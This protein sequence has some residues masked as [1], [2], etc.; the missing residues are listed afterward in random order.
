VDCYLFHQ[1][2]R[3][4]VDTLSKRI[5]LD[6]AKVRVDIEDIGNT[7][8]SS[9]PLLLQRELAD[10]A[11]KTIV[12]CGFGVGLSLAGCVCKRTGD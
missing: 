3:Y 10:P 8:S 6:R 2:S 1:G 5:G 12:L 4:I 9:I 11:M 7:V